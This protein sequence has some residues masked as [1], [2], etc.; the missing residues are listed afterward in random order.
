MNDEIDVSNF[1]FYI[2][3]YHDCNCADVCPYY[4]DYCNKEEEK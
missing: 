2:G 4:D 3:D 1:C